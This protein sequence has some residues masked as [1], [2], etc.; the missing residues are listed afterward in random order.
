MRGWA[1]KGVEAKWDVVEC[2]W[3]R[4][5]EGAVIADERKKLAHR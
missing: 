2:G 1:K 3:D 5:K 4:V